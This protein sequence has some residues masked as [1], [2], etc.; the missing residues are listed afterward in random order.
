MDCKANQWPRG[1]SVTV[2]PVATPTHENAAAQWLSESEES[3]KPG[4]EIPLRVRVTNAAESKREQ[5]QLR[6]QGA[7]AGALPIDAY[8][9]RRAG[10]HRPHLR[11]ASRRDRPGVERG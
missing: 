7:P 10:A 2:D 11:A 9:P 6:W 1:I 5:L 3:D 4:E 8:V